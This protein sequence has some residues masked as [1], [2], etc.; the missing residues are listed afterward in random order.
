MAQSRLLRNINLGVKSLVLHKL[1]SF[2]TILG[3]VFGVGSV[4]SMLS[5]GLMGL[6]MYRF[7]SEEDLSHPGLVVGIAAHH[8]EPGKHVRDEWW[9]LRRCMKGHDR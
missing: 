2:L 1:R 4:V 5:V 6:V 9:N 3:V 7:L 8:P